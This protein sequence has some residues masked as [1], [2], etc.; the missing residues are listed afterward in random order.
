[1]DEFTGETT[2]GQGAIT[3]GGDLNLGIFLHG[4][5]LLYLIWLPIAPHTL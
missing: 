4:N 2:L 5:L 3:F 1:L